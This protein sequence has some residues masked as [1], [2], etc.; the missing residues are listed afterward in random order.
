MFRSTATDRFCNFDCDDS[1]TKIN[2]VFLPKYFEMF[3]T[4][5]CSCKNFHLFNEVGEEGG[6]FRG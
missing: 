1:K 3:M 5:G 6:A 2:L 4:C